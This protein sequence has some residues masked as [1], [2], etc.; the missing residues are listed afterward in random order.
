MARIEQSF[1]ARDT[2][3]VA[4]ELLGLYLV[5]ELPEGR[6]VCRITETE[7]YVGRIDKACHAYGYKRTVRTEPLFAAP[8]TLYIYLIYGMYHCLNL[9]TE[10][11]GEPCAVLLRGAEPVAGLSLLAHNR[12]GK[13]TEAL[14]RQ[15]RA[16]F[17]NGP[18]KL[19]SALRLTRAENKRPLGGTLW[20][21]DSLADFG[22]PAQTEPT[23]SIQASPRI[24]IPYAEEATD[25]PWRFCLD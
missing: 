15:Q 17:L 3:A 11:E 21:S 18:G 2:L 14:S 24:N 20:L 19:C 13:A 6:L 22:L 5:R 8:G 9:V 12:F 10:A 25:F 7:A 1:F 16:N 23:R 4:R